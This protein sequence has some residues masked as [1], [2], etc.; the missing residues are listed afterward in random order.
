MSEEEII[1]EIENYENWKVVYNPVGVYQFIPLPKNYKQA[2]EGILDLY[3]KEKENNKKLDRENQ[4]L[5]IIH[6]SYKE[7]I[8]ENNLISKD[9]IIKAMGIT[10]ED[11][12]ECKAK[13]STDEDYLVRMI[14]L[15]SDEFE[16]LE[17][18][19]DKKVQ[20]EYNNVFNKGAKSV[21][22]KIRKRIKELEQDMVLP[23]VRKE[24]QELLEE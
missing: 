20:I 3:Q 14:K 4:A 23:E 9:K 21:K 12:K 1:K 7:M 2:I 19:E 22:D 8:E 13:G 17:D 11:I 15:Y 10:Q 24:L 16:R 5:E 6:K 18:I